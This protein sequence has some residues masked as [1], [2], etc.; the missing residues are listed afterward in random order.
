MDTLLKNA[1]VTVCVCMLTIV[2]NIQ[3]HFFLTKL[4]TQYSTSGNQ[5]QGY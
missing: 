2:S 3:K 5:C 4:P 1:V